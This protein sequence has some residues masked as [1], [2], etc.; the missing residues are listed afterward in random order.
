[1]SRRSLVTGV[2]LF[3]AGLAG[4]AVGMAQEAAAPPAD[5]AAPV[6]LKTLEDKAAY[7]IGQN[8]GQQ[9]LQ[10]KLPLNPE[11][12][13]RGLTDALKKAKP[14]LTMEEVEAT[15]LAF[16]K[17]M[18]LKAAAD[19]AAKDPAAAKTLKDGQAFLASN[20]VAKGI[21][22]TDSGLQY[23]V[24]ASGK[25]PSPKATD[26]VRVHYQ[27]TLI[28]GQVFDSSIE[29]GEPAEFRVGGVI[30]GWT[31]ALQLMKV[32]DKWRLYVPNDLAYGPE[33]RGEHI[34][35][36]SVLIF[37]VELLEIVK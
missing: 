16:S 3:L 21:T 28:S 15:M 34:T 19:L 33:S 20:K 32:G 30:A 1:M 26:K 22:T 4:Y 25:G 10:D 7:A 5:P 37:D 27:G 6:E 18:R 29:R 14:A 23:K 12:I 31:E 35:P 17:K 36:F 9:I 8:I 11:L 24:L 2:L 13:A